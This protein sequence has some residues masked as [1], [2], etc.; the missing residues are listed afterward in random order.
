MLYSCMCRSVH[1]QLHVS[2]SRVFYSL[3]LSLVSDCGCI[4]FFI[5]GFFYLLISSFD[6]VS[7][8]YSLRIGRFFT[9][10]MVCFLFTLNNWGIWEC[11]CCASL[12]DVLP[13][14]PKLHSCVDVRL[15]LK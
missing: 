12:E 13:Y 1:S 10:L 11:W 4:L 6:M 8:L 9:Y 7:F 5:L 3:L 14:T 15:G 2:D